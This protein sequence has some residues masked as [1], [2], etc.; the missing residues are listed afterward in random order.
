MNKV[1]TSTPIEL[2]DLIQITGDSLNFAIA[3]FKKNKEFFPILDE[4]KDLRLLILKSL[5]QRIDVTLMSYNLMFDDSL[6]QAL[7][8]MWPNI[9]LE[10]QIDK[11]KFLFDKSRALTGNYKSSLF[12]NVFLEFEHFIRIIGK[13]IDP[14]SSNEQ[15]INKYSKNIIDTLVI[16]SS[17]KSLIDLLTYSRNTIHSGGFQTREVS[18]IEYKGVQYNLIKGHHVHFFDDHFLHLIIKELIELIDLIIHTPVIESIPYIPHT[19]ADL[20]WEDPEE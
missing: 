10:N 9:K 17:Y 19:Y 16:D 11:E 2:E 4:N 5:I 14:N 15:S 8:R 6:I 13:T 7:K 1:V 18:P 20:T 12:I 3:K